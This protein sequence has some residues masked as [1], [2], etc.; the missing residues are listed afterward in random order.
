MTWTC[1]LQ[2]SWDSPTYTEC[3]TPYKSIKTQTE[4]PQIKFPYTVL[5]TS[6]VL[7]RGE[8]NLFLFLFW[9][10]LQNFGLRKKNHFVNFN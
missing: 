5:H 7:N 10:R 4:N 2:V 9:L 3:E 8:L 1:S 6:S